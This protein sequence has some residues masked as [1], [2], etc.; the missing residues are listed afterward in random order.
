[1]LVE[2]GQL[3]AS[4]LRAFLAESVQAA[5]GAAR[6]GRF[7]VFDLLGEPSS[8]LKPGQQRVELPACEAGQLHQLIAVAWLRDVIEED[9]QHGGYGNRDPHLVHR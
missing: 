6:R 8:P 2:P 4:R 5:G 7:D 9:A 1:M 3:V